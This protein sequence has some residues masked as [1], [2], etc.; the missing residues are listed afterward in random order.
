MKYFKRISPNNV[1]MHRHQHLDAVTVVGVYGKDQFGVSFL[2]RSMCAEEMGCALRWVRWVLRG[3]GTAS[4]HPSI[5]TVIAQR[6]D[7]TGWNKFGREYRGT[8]SKMDCHSASSRNLS[9]F[10]DGTF[11]ISSGSLFQYGTTRTLNTC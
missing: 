3:T 5:A 7:T 2:R 10:T 9:V 11:T 6:W 4:V 1:L 8:S